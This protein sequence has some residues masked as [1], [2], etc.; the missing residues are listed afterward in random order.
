ML[1]YYSSCYCAHCLQQEYDQ[2]LN[3]EYVTP[4]VK[5]TVLPQSGSV[6]KVLRNE[7]K[8]ELMTGT[9]ELVCEVSTVAI[10]A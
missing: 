2:C 10:A 1:L 6:P 8:R 7:S 3:T 4:W 5:H 9:P